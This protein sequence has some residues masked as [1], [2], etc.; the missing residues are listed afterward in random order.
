[1]TVHGSVA[2]ERHCPDLRW[3]EGQSLAVLRGGWQG[4]VDCAPDE[5]VECRGQR[6]SRPSSCPGQ[7][8]CFKAME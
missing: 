6:A 3:G 4:L 7:W 8:F 5:G 2:A 1:M